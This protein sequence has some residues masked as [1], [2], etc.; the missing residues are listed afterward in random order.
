MERWLQRVYARAPRRYGVVLTLTAIPFALL[1]T[2][3]AVLTLA[4]MFEA[5]HVLVPLLLAGA[6]M[7]VGCVLVT[8]ALSWTFLDPLLAWGR[9]DRD[10]DAAVKAWLVANDMTRVVRR[11]I[12]V[13]VVANIPYAVYATGVLDASAWAIPSIVAGSL[14]TIAWGAA[15]IVLW[16]DLATR[17]LLEDIAAIL[18]NE[19]EPKAPL[20][21][22]RGK[23]FATSTAF[24]TANIGLAAG[25]ASR[26]DLSAE[27][28]IVFI[29]GLAIVASVTVSR[30][31]N[32][33]AVRSIF[34]P[35]RD[36]VAAADAVRRGDLTTRLPV[37]SGD[38]F[39][40]LTHSFN[41]MVRGLAEREA[42]RSALGS[43][44]DPRVAERLLAE[45]EL[46]DGAYVDVTILFLDI[47]GFTT[48]SEH[49]DA[50]DTVA[51]LN[52][53]FARIVPLVAAYGGH[54]NKFTGDGLL[55]VFGT[56]EHHDDHADRAVAAAREIVRTMSEQT[57]VG[58]GIG[59]N[60]GKV[61]AGTIGGGGHLEFAVIGDAVNVASRVEGLTKDIGDA[62]LVTGATRGR[63][64]G[65]SDQLAPRG[66]HVVRG[67]S[68]PIDVYAL[69]LDG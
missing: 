67:R 41:R 32:A 19:F 55:A 4:V 8:F 23:L 63:L 14:I 16:F 62:V 13:F 48:Q 60:S 40:S 5:L 52:D 57:P 61:V 50:A 53:L 22:A 66:S 36:L 47:R 65:S 44:V 33:F 12:A 3:T 17:P 18:P 51:D 64:N 11:G 7:G 68:E 43:Y 24:A 45:G 2:E 56:P 59:I 31:G 69:D 37:L 58:F 39:G 35:I 27:V 38:E 26:V 21:S 1:A 34:D 49:R 25:L 9:S 54:V 42:L 28:A 29:L 46:L 30:I 15:L 10:A 6:V 20:L